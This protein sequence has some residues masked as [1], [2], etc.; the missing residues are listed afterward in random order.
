VTGGSL[1]RWQ[2]DQELCCHI[3]MIFSNQIHLIVSN[4]VQVDKKWNPTQ[5]SYINQLHY[6]VCSIQSYSDMMF[7]M[8][9]EK[10]QAW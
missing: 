9:F 6:T 2:Y 5:D 4:H 10:Y 8:K 7:A 3:D 1:T